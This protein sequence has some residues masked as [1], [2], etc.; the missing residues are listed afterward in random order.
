MAEND[1]EKAWKLAEKIGFCMLATREGEEIRSRPMAAYVNRDAGTIFF[2]TDVASHKDEDI[3]RH[4]N[5]NLAFADTSGQT[6]VSVSGTATISNDREKIKEL[7]G[8]PP[9]PGGRART[10]PRSGC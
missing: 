7:W 2:L 10:I 4:P 1:V 6:Y 9:R 5:V 3:S 8:R